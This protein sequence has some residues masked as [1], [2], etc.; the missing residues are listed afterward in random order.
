[1]DWLK[2]NTG[3]EVGYRI[4]P[5]YDTKLTTG[6]RFDMVDRS[7]AQVGKS[8]TNTGTVALSSRLGPQVNGSLSYAHGE[9]SGVLNY[10]TPWQNL[11]GP[12]SVASPDPSGAY[13]QAPMTS[14]A[15]KLRADYAPMQNLSSGL[16]LQ[17]K[18]EDYHYPQ[19]FNTN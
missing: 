19:T 15:V 2:Q 7:N 6:Y 13:Y 12:N 17:F 11:N 10:L 18:N 4:L 16:F 1:Q 14:D 5:Q 9:R 3:F 8:T